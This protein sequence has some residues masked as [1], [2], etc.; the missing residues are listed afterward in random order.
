HSEQTEDNSRQRL[1][2]PTDPKLVLRNT[3]T[4][5]RLYAQLPDLTWLTALLPGLHDELRSRRARVEGADRTMVA[6]GRLIAA[7][8]EVRLTGWPD[9]DKPFIQLEDGDSLSNSVIQEQAKIT[10]GPIWVF[11]RRGRGVAVE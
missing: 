11:K 7:S 10:R 4:G 6:R 1:P 5:W 3:E 2:K 8:Q 9:P